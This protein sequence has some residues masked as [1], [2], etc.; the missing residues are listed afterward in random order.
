MRGATGRPLRIEMVLPSLET[1]GMEAVVARL[2]RRLGERGLAVSYTVTEAMGDFAE[3]LCAEGHQVTLV[4]QPRRFSS[5][6]TAALEQHFRARA[7]DI[8]HVHSGVWLKAAKAARHDPRCGV[9][10]TIHGLFAKEPWY[11]NTV[12]RMAVRHTDEIIAVST[13]LSDFLRTEIGVPASRITVLPNG[14]D[15]TVFKPAP[16][17]GRLRAELGIPADGY[18]IGTV[19]RLDAVKNQ[20]LLVDAFRDVCEQRTAAAHAGAHLLFVGDGPER[21]TLTARAQAYGL[22]DRVHFAGR[23]SID[24]H[25]YAELDVFALPSWLEGTS[26]SLLEAMACGLPVVATAVGGTTEILQHSPVPALVS[27]NDRPALA[28]LLARFLHDGS[29]GATAGRW[30]RRHV[31]DHYSEAV[32]VNTYA[33]AYQR[34]HRR[35]WLPTRSS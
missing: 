1:G 29:A 26:M 7:P 24:A 9:L 2:G 5:V 8:V 10:H 32:M 28:V 15:T 6:R 30:L 17:A 21:A 12:K 16:R 25:L 27:S 31:E 35:R 20:S 4:R 23:R 33:E 22:A 18:V 3:E 34:I 13:T 14:V 11:G 19:A